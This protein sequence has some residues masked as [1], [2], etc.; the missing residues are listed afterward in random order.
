LRPRLLRELIFTCKHFCELNEQH[1]ERSA[2]DYR[3]GDIRAQQNSVL[4][5][6]DLDEEPHAQSDATNFDTIPLPATALVLDLSCLNLPSRFLWHG[7]MRLLV[8]DEYRKAV[9]F[10]NGRPKGR[11]GSV[12]LTGQPGIDRSK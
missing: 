4:E 10:L 8:R 6:V 11:S 1:P 5:R 3:G 12:F 2:V 9:E 7:Q